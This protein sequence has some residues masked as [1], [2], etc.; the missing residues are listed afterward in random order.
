[1]S[2][3]LAACTG[4]LFMF[5][6][7]WSVAIGSRAAHLVVLLLTSAGRYKAGDSKPPGPRSAIFND[8]RLRSVEPLISLLRDIG[9]SH[10]GK[11]PAQVAVNWNIC[12]GTLPIVGECSAMRTFCTF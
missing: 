10:G 8:D 9:Q 5:R 6:I 4:M 3:L 2:L 11:T 1:M 12:K 7:A